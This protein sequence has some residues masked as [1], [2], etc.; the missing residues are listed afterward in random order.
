[1]S[2]VCTIV[3]ERDEGGYFV[4]YASALP[5]CHTQAQSIVR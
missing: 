2:S 3:I 5:G 4:G 1:M